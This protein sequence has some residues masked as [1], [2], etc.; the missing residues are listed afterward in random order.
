MYAA[1]LLI[2]SAV[3]GVDFGYQTT[4]QNQV[5]CVVQIEPEAIEHLKTGKAIQI[6]MP[7]N[8]ERVEVFRVQI[9]SEKLN[10]PVTYEKPV[11]DNFD[12]ISE[13][14]LA[15]TK[16]PVLRA[17]PE[18]G[19]VADTKPT[20]G[21][22]MAQYIPR[23]TRTPP[24]GA[25]SPAPTSSSSTAA[26]N[27][28][29]TLPTIP[30]AAERYGGAPSSAAS[31]FSVPSTPGSP[32][33]TTQA[34]ATSP[35][36]SPGNSSTSPS[37]PTSPNGTS[38]LPSPPST[39][40]SAANTGTPATGGNSWSASTSNNNTAGNTQSP[41]GNTGQSTNGT[42]NQFRFNQQPSSTNQPAPDL[43][44][45]SD[46]NNWVSN[47]GQSNNGSNYGNNLPNQGN[48]GNTQ[49]GNN[50]S[51]P[52]N[53]SNN[54]FPYNNG[55]QQPNQPNN[56]QNPQ[57][58][59]GDNSWLTGAWNN[60]QNNGSSAPYSPVPNTNQPPQNNQPPY[61][62]Q[63]QGPNYNN[64][65][66]PPYNGNY[67][68]NAYGQPPYNGYGPNQFYGQN[69]PASYQA[70]FPQQQLPAHQVASLPP[71]PATQQPVAQQPTTATPASPSE[72]AKEPKE[73]KETDTK[74]VEPL[75]T[76]WPFLAFGFLLSFCA[77]GYMFIISQD[78]QRKYQDLLE[79][80]RDLRTMSND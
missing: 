66:Q 54:G 48:T 8:A 18:P 21:D 15:P 37:S 58:G 2:S 79:D 12:E 73:S 57:N 74:P 47:N 32:Y 72:P 39:T 34:S 19:S 55:S 22:E 42:S 25:S 78:F 43:I 13:I 63:Y 14:G 50:M 30:G 51:P 33:N 5:E 7:P 6:E 59:S 16:T 27:T 49:S 35:V 4:D 26:N 69:V 1:C 10:L 3:L 24:S 31:R 80:V 20:L 62:N 41:T 36:G 65:Q 45:P 76:W 23:S 40:G 64:P 38:S 68:N 61:N 67:V 60:N 77:N 70:P 52:N 17:P 56:N 28:G 46:S 53:N 71:T 11:D 44:S 29:D 9:G 75:P